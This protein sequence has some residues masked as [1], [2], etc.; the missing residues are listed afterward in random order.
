[1]AE[2]AEKSEKKVAIS[3]ERGQHGNAPVVI[4]TGF[5]LRPEK[6]TGLLDVLIEC[7]GQKNARVCFD[8]VIVKQNL[9]TLKEYV[10]R[11]GVEP[12]DL[13][14]KEDVTPSDQVY[15]AN[16]VHL[17]QMGGRSETAFAA[18][19]LSEWV[20]AT[21]KDGKSATVTSYDT[22][23]M[24]SSAELQKKFVLELL[25]ALKQYYNE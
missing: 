22:L 15:F 18:F 4:A 16:V 12:D 8:P 13:A 10:A 7:L 14:I 19:R 25:L 23:V 1:M 9:Q 11:L 24:V 2:K 21:R 3:M 17:S 20:E 5:K 6:A